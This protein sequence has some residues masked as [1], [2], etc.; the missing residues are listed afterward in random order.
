MNWEHKNGVSLIGK[1]LWGK[2]KPCIPGS[3]F[4]RACKKEVKYG[5]R[6]KTALQTHIDNG[7]HLENLAL[8]T[9]AN[10]QRLG[11]EYLPDDGQDGNE[12][13]GRVSST[14]C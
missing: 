13:D 10:Q 14:C 9:D 1:E 4:C 3:M 11:S 12:G 7:S 2:Y 6:G 8:F 5:N